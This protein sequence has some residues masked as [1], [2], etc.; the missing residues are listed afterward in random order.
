MG[1]W[2]QAALRLG[3]LLAVLVVGAG[4]GLGLTRLAL[5]GQPPFGG[6]R[7]GAWRAW[8]G[9]GTAGIDPYARAIYARD[10]R[11][12]LAAATG[13]VFLARTDDA[14]APLSGRCAYAVGGPTPDAQFWT[15]TPLDGAGLTR[16]AAG[17]RAGF[18]SAEVVRDAAGNF[19]IELAREARPG[20]WLPLPADE[21]FQLM[22]AVYDTPVTAALNAG[23]APPALPAIVRRSCR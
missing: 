8:P 5:G 14:G 18:T 11:V 2:R 4:L 7:S 16:A 3:G 19:S 21:P 22:L 10:G 17:E 9:S 13:L 1:G 23:A 12:P 6:V 20:N 15:L